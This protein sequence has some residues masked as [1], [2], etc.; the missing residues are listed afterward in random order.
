MCREQSKVRAGHI[1]VVAH[2][3]LRL[4]LPAL[5]S[6]A[7]TEG[8]WMMWLHPLSAPHSHLPFS[9]GTP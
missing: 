2:T 3:H 4:R 5:S 6:R 9:R 1:E 8:L 7:T